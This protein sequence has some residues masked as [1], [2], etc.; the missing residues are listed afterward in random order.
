MSAES[1]LQQFIHS[2]TNVE[3]ILPILKS[4]SLSDIKN[5]AIQNL[6]KINTKKQKKIYFKALPITQ[7]VPDDLI[8]HILTFNKF[9][10]TR[11]V[12][13]TF[14]LFTDKNE[15][16]YYEKLHQS[17]NK[18]KHNETT[19]IVVNQ[20]RNKLYPFEEKARYK[21]PCYNI[22]QAI[23][24]CDNDARIV[25]HPGE[26]KFYDV[27]NITENIQIIGL[28]D[29]NNGDNPR[30]YCNTPIKTYSNNFI[31]EN[32]TIV[33]SSNDVAISVEK[34]KFQA[35]RCMFEKSE[36][37]ETNLYICKKKGAIAKIE[38]STFQTNK[39]EVAIDTCNVVI[40]N[41]NEFGKEIIY[42]TTDMEQSKMT[43]EY[44][45]LNRKH[46]LQL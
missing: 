7:I 17:L 5:F 3:Q 21:G 31:L 32:I 12:N 37:I 28:N 2:A 23:E 19:T 36:Y 6:K 43:I 20:H 38:N 18:N 15:K 13:K 25:I 39:Q 27:V 11:F 41:Y 45:A 16:N 44:Y 26:Y 35:S 34:G 10:D 22:E 33:S 1:L 9:G 8:Q 29:R 46:W 14:K 42:G 24:L 40:N 4:L 30:I